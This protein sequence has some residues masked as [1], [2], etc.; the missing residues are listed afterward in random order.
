MFY[1]FFWQIFSLSFENFSN[2]NLLILFNNVFCD[3]KALNND[4]N[5]WF[6]LDVNPKAR[7]LDLQKSKGS[8]IIKK[9][10]FQKI[11]LNDLVMNLFFL[12][13]YQ[14]KLVFLKN[15]ACELQF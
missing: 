3:N 10:V 4:G 1:K 8:K 12:M 15:I 9:N 13:I 6:L 7:F 5:K 2:N 11:Y 14:C